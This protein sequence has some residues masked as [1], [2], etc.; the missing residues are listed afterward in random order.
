M[1][2]DRSRQL[3]CALLGEEDRRLRHTDD[4]HGGRDLC[5]AWGSPL[6]FFFSSFFPHWPPLFNFI[7]YRNYLSFMKIRHWMWKRSGTSCWT[8][9]KSSNVLRPYSSS[10]V[11]FS[12][13]CDL[14]NIIYI[15]S[16]YAY[17]SSAVLWIWVGPIGDMEVVHM[18]FNSVFPVSKRDVVAFKAY[19]KPGNGNLSISLFYM[20]LHS[21]YLLLLI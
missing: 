13:S 3:G 2:R 15:F 6:P 5:F 16:I 20:Y 18:Q 19:K 1:E 17:V 12:S 4:A 11:L 10:C 8:T 21:I 14:Q 7:L 9:W